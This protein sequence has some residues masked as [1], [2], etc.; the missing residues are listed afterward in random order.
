[1]CAAAETRHDND[2]G[3]GGKFYLATEYHVSGTVTDLYDFSYDYSGTIAGEFVTHAAE[4]EDVVCARFMPP[5][6]PEPGHGDF[7]G[8]RQLTDAERS[9][10]GVFV[11]Q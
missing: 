2:D 9:T 7:L 10:R 4:L 6:L 3:N 11:R 1:M 8:A 5:W